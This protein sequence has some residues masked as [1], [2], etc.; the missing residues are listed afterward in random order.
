[1]FCIL[2]TF[3]GHQ[4]QHELPET[5]GL[6]V[7]LS[8]D[9]TFQYAKTYDQVFINSIHNLGYPGRLNRIFLYVLDWLLQLM[10]SS[11]QSLQLVMNHK[12]KYGLI[13]S[14]V[15]IKA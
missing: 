8:L 14:K 11:F 4:L 12:V 13:K 5:Q 1:M 9:K 10:S 2:V 3:L 6:L 15:Q 7:Y